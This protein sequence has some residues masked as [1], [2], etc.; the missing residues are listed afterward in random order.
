MTK[1]DTTHL[2]EGKK[3]E[4]EKTSPKQ[5]ADDLDLLHV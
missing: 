3:R 5:K 2:T 4:G 1:R